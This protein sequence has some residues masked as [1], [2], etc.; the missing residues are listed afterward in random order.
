MLADGRDVE[1]HAGGVLNL[2]ADT[3]IKISTLAPASDLEPFVAHYGIVSWNVGAQTATVSELLL[4]PVIHLV[5]ERN[6]SRVTGVCRGRFTRRFADRGRAFGVAFKPG[7]FRVLLGVLPWR[8]TDQSVPLA[9]LVGKDARSLEDAVLA[10]HDDRDSAALI[11]RFLRRRLPRG[12]ESLALVQQAFSKIIEDRE[13]TRVDALVRSTGIP[14]RSLER[15]FRESIGVSPKWVIRHF[16][17]RRAFAGL[18]LPRPD[19]ADLA[20]SLGYF[21]QAHFTH[22]FKAV[23]GLTPMTCLRLLRERH[24]SS[25]VTDGK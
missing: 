17:L 21:D 20:A 4:E 22:E 1:Q 5:V 18:A 8:L 16:R 2:G 3:G 6:H 15:L 13:I 19:L 23:T 25:T 14:M 12:A 7:A 9:R 10:S 11:D 24:R